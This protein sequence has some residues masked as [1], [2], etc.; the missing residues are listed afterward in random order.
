MSLVPTGKYLLILAMASVLTL[1]F[2]MILNPF[3][4]IMEV[5]PARDI[6]LAIFPNGL[7]LAILLIATASYL[8]DMQREK[9]GGT[10]NGG[11]GY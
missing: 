2:G 3:F 6:L 1:V 11:G 7:L 9:Q 8:I 10:G 4:C 5:G